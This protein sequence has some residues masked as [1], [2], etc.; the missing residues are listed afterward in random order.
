MLP[1]YCM[2]SNVFYVFKR[3]SQSQADEVSVSKDTL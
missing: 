2:V 3:S 1:G